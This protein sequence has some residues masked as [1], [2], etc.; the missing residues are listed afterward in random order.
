[1]PVQDLKDLAEGNLIVVA[2]G[3]HGF[4]Q[5]AFFRLGRFERTNQRQSDLALAQVV[6][7]RFA[8]NLL[9]GREIE[10]VVD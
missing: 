3:E 8:E 7:D 4:H 5:T 9:A 10:H 1:M 2:I 6:A